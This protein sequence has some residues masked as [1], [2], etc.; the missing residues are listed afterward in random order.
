[1]AERASYRLL[2]ILLFLPVPLVL[3]L[4][5]QAPLGT[6]ASLGLGVLVM[7]THRLY[8]RPFSLGAAERRC[9]WCGRATAE[10][11]RFDVQEPFGTTTWRGCT[12]HHAVLAGRVLAWAER[13]GALL[14]VGILGSLAAFLA[15]AV[16][17]SRG[18]LA[19]WTVA[20]CVNLFRLGIALSVLPL[21]L[22]GPSGNRAAPAI[23]RPP[24]PV[25]IQALIGTA[26][27]LWLFRLIGLAWL[28]L[29][30]IHFARRLGLLG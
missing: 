7:V 13:H 4:F 10:G 30:G 29:A 28:A 17:A 20:D 25:H 21:G 11:P 16:L 26:A 22:L 23:P 1:M 19:P 14:K 3:F 5:T 6:G 18:G 8:A 2:G 9:L 12:E 15:S 24:F 27:V